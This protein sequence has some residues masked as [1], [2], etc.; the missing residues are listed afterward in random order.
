MT[1]QF[2]V[3][4]APLYLPIMFALWWIPLFIERN[5]IRELNSWNTRMYERIS[6]TNYVIYLYNNWEF[7]WTF[8]V[9]QPTIIIEC[10]CRAHSYCHQCFGEL[11]KSFPNTKSSLILFTLIYGRKFRLT[12]FLSSLFRILFGC[13][14]TSQTVL[15]RKQ[16]LKCLS[17][18]GR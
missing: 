5:S 2:N 10:F 4:I 15:T 3:T 8:V 7:K 11:F 12:L 6:Y 1:L 17:F 18:W 13:H 14:H 16:Q 9:E